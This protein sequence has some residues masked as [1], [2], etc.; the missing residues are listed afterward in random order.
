M[1]DQKSPPAKPLRLVPRRQFLQGS[2]LAAGSLSASVIST[3]VSAQ[4]ST[5]EASPIASPAASPVSDQPVLSAAE[6]A[7]LQAAVNRIFPAD[8]Y[9]PSGV[10]AGVDVYIHRSLG[11]WL[12][13]SLPLY[14]GGLKALDGATGPDGFAAAD[15]ATQDD[16]LTQAEAGTLADAPEGFFAALL[17]HCR[18]GM[19][20]DPIYGGNQNFAGWDL[21]NYPGVKLVWTEE[22]QSTDT[23][24]E[25]EHISVAQFGRPFSW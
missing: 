20:S 1:S 2:A 10:E 13:A 22:D 17:E 15:A 19:F 6:V 24:V 14:Q 8:E 25:P 21:I 7:T 18:Q 11:G 4:N 12:S 9:G 16:V 5:P 23:T 3:R